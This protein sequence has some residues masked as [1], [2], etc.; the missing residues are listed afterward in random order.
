MAN[1]YT[2]YLPVK[3]CNRQRC[4]EKL[5]DASEKWGWSV[6]DGNWQLPAAAFTHIPAT[7]NHTTYPTAEPAVLI[8][9][10]AE[11]KKW[12]KPY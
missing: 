7:C 1:E 8:V 6:C 3:K 5:D 11:I 4:G 9:K 2:I 10:L 12:S